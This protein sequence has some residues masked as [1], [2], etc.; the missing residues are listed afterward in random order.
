MI[1]TPNKLL[2]FDEFITQYGDSP[3]YELA[4]GEL[5]DMEPTGSHQTVGGKLAPKISSAIGKTSYP[6]F[7]PLTCLIRS[8]IDTTLRPDII[9]LDETML[10]AEP[11][12]E[13][14]TV[15]SYGSSILI[16]NF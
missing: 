14:L 6:W 13:K 15:T 1:Y 12:W 11:L 4:D 9:V 2:S 7:I 5:I 16:I 3:H 10:D 8:A